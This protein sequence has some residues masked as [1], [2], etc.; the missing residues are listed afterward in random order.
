MLVPCLGAQADCAPAAAYVPDHVSPELQ[1]ALR[2]SA[3]AV[4]V[5]FVEPRTSAEWKAL[6]A[7]QSNPA[8]VKAHNDALLKRFPVKWTQDRLAGVPVNVLTPAVIPPANRNRV[9]MHLHGGSYNSG[10][11]ITGITEPLLLAHYAHMKVVSVDYR[12][13]PDHPF[14]AAVEDSVAVW[15]ELLKT[16]N[17][18]NAGIGGTS[19]GGGLTL[20][21]VLK[22]KQLKLPLPAAIFAGTPWADLTNRG[23]TFVLAQCGDPDKSALSAA[24]RLYAANHDLHDPLL[25][26]VN[27]DF[28]HFPPA[29]LVSGTRDVLLSDTVRVHRKLRSAGVEASLHV[30]EAQRHADYMLVSEAPESGEVLLEVAEFFDRHLGH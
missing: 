1:Q 29:I 14:P 8:T 2:K 21:T 30:F 5:P 7:S 6:L 15:K 11:G 9:L 17:P 24:G 4:A 28:A 16:V 3:S 26:P 20:A 18:A 25:S 13:P 23:D 19:A 22:L 12:M 27:G 10:G